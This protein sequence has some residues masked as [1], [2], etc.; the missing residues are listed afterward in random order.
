VVE[1]ADWWL[2]VVSYMINKQRKFVVVDIPRY[3]VGEVR[4]LIELES[5]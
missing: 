4:L 3:F 2:G 5:D 1:L